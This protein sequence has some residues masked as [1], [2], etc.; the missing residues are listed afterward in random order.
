MYIEAYGIFSIY[1]EEKT[2]PG[3]PIYPQIDETMYDRYESV[4]PGEKACAN[5]GTVQQTASIAC[6]TCGKTDWVKAIM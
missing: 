1:Q 4:S 6:N 2:K 5:C 3:L